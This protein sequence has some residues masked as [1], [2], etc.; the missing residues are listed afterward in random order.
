MDDGGEVRFVAGNH[1]SIVDRTFTHGGFSSRMSILFPGVQQS[2]I[3]S[4]GA[5]PE[6]WN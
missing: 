6:I 1:S 3:H 5:S 4:D 2:D